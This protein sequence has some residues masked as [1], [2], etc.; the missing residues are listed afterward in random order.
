MF[1]KL[2]M[3]LT[4]QEGQSSGLPANSLPQFLQNIAY[5][6]FAPNVLEPTLCSGPIHQAQSHSILHLV[7]SSIC[8]GAPGRGKVMAFAG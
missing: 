2:V 4:P 6:L 8:L 3:G 7:D 1:P 5:L